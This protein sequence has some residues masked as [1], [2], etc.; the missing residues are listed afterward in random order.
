MEK[1]EWSEIL[2]ATK[3]GNKCTQRDFVFRNVFTGSENCLFLNV[4]T[5]R[6]SMTATNKIVQL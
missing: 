6:V 3:E 2:K 4:Y 5:P 1:Q